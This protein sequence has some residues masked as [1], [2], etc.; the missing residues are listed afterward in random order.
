M[1]AKATD[2]PHEYVAWESGTVGVCRAGLWGLSA[3]MDPDG[4]TVLTSGPWALLVEGED[5]YHFDRT[6]AT[7][8]GNPVPSA[9]AIPIP[10]EVFPALIERMQFALARAANCAAPVA[11]DGEP[12]TEEG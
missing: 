1:D 5:P 6:G 9:Y 8:G 2:W 10:L 11:T 4:G 12:Q 7:E 3:R